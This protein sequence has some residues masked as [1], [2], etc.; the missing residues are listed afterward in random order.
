MNVTKSWRTPCRWHCIIKIP[1]RYVSK[2]NTKPFIWYAYIYNNTHVIITAISNNEPHLFY[3]Q[4]LFEWLKSAELRSAE[5]FVVGTD[6]ESVKEQLC[7]LKVC[8]LSILP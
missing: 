2:C 4:G 8:S 5:E 7:D 6:L 3:Y 1:C